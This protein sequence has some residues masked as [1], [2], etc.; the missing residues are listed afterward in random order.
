MS[1]IENEVSLY[2]SQGFAVLRDLLPTDIVQAAREEYV[3]VYA[4][5]LTQTP[6][7]DEAFMVM[8]HVWTAP[9]LQGD[10]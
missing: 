3:S 5:A 10:F 1:V 2:D 9:A 8:W 7:T 6:D 4:G